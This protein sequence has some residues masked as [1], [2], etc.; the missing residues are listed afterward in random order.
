MTA[1]AGVLGRFD[2]ESYGARPIGFCKGLPRYGVSGPGFRHCLHQ[3]EAQ[4]D[5]SPQ[6]KTHI[7]LKVCFAL[8]AI[9]ASSHFVHATTGSQSVPRLASFSRPCRRVGRPGST[10]DGLRVCCVALSLLDD[11]WIQQSRH[12]YYRI[13]QSVAQSRDNPLFG[14][15]IV[16]LCRASWSRPGF[17]PK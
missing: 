13:C 6:P 16:P 14:P 17:W 2:R 3:E 9:S 5:H 1:E 11:N 4:I 8:F 15:K 12:V 7:T 10:S